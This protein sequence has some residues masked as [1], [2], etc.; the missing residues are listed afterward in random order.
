MINMSSWSRGKKL[1]A[2]R[3]FCVIPDPIVVV[4]VGVVVA[5]HI[6]LDRCL[7]S[8]MVVVGWSVGQSVV[9]LVCPCPAFVSRKSVFICWENRTCRWVQAGCSVEQFVNGAIAISARGRMDTYT[10]NRNLIISRRCTITSL[11][12]RDD[13]TLLRHI[14]K[15][16]KRITILT[17]TH[18][19]PNWGEWGPCK[20]MRERAG[21]K[22]IKT[23]AAMR[24]IAKSFCGLQ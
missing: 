7:A 16:L 6:N 1:I 4:V 10:S 15:H 8:S 5:L 13:W 18:H 2:C 12:E 21:T 19:S 9:W 24:L 14:N 23:D 22:V 20:W 17:P 11:S 3:A